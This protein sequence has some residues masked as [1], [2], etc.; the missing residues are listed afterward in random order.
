MI[1]GEHG[2]STGVL[3]PGEIVTESGF[4]LALLRMLQF[5]S[6]RGTWN[7]QRVLAIL[8]LGE[9]VVCVA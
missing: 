3:K 6:K 1:Y 7:A 9:K 4:E 8:T 2:L 5:T